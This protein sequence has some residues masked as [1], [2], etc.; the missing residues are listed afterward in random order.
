MSDTILK[1]NQ[2]IGNKRNTILF[3]YILQLFAQK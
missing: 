2:I 1:K 3:I